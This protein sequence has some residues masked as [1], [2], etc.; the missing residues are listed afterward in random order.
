MEKQT[1]IPL[2]IAAS[3]V[4][5]ALLFDLA[6]GLINLIPFVGQVV[7]SIGGLLGML[8][9]WVWF[10]LQGVNFVSARRAIALFGASLIEL[11]PVLNVLPALT[12]GVI[13]TIVLTNLED[14]T[15]RTISLP[16]KVKPR[17]L[18]GK[19]PVIPGTGGVA[20]KLPR[21]AGDLRRAGI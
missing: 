10:Q 11:I 16:R 7:S 8:T 13:T 14:R 17:S 19:P 12:A 2:V 18:P 9:F 21:S 4:V 3:M 6:N 5:T 15:G 20:S 1:R